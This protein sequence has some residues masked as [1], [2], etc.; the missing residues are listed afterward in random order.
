MSTFDP[1]SFLAQDLSGASE[2]KYTAVPESDQKAFVGD[3]KME[4]YKDP[5]R[6]D[7]PVLA[8][9]WNLLDEDGKLKATL[10]LDKPTVVDKIF[11]DMNPDGTIAFGPNKNV[12]LGRVREAVGQNDP[13]KKWS[14]NQLRGA[15][16]VLLKIEHGYNKQTGEGPFA[17]VA[18]VVKAV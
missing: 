16:P 12:R 18:K 6:G 7:V 3:L 14:F 10:G 5:E 17:R 1:D 8:L 11:I 9:T 13:K 15:G 2:T 4:T